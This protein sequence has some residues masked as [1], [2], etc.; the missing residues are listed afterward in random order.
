M[1]I[2]QMLAGDKR[3]ASTVR[4]RRPG[5]RASR[6]ADDDA[7]LACALAARVDLVACGNDDL[8]VLRSVS[9]SP[10]SRW[11]QPPSAS[12][13]SV[14]AACK[15]LIGHRLAHTDRPDCA[16]IRIRAQ[17]CAAILDMGA[18]LRQILVRLE[19]PLCYRLGQ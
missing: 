4:A 10:S 2:Q 7:V 19:S 6:D 12:T 1:S 5:E 9:E 13:A 8:L 17:P 11:P 15:P 3:I 18:D 16:H 14:E